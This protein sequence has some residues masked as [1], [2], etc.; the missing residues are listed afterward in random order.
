MT[1]GEDQGNVE[2]PLEMGTRI[3]I[4]L[5]RLVRHPKKSTLLSFD[6]NDP[7]TGFSG[8]KK[9]IWSTDKTLT[10]TV[11]QKTHRHYRLE[12]SYNKYTVTVSVKTP[13]KRGPK[14]PPAATPTPTYA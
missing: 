9:M 6:L 8:R 4:V 14:A 3:N 13:P 11:I 2:P 12:T 10:G 5:S 1:T 7:V